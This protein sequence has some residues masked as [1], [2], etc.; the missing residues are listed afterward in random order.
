MQ[1]PAENSTQQIRAIAPYKW[2]CTSCTLQVLPF[3]INVEDISSDNDDTTP[4]I[5]HS[6]QPSLSTD[7]FK[8]M[9]DKQQHL[10]KICHLINT[11][12]MLSTFDEFECLINQYPFDIITLS[13]TWLKD[14]QHVLDYVRIPGYSIEFR[15]RK[16]RRGGGVGIYMRD[17]IKSKARSE[18]II[19]EH[20]FEHIWLEIEGKN[21]PGGLPT[22]F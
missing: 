9:I 12:S 7:K 17:N 3:F 13:E 2:I 6:E 18:I 14:N 5:N 19:L 10:L 21:K 8:S 16:D 11:Q 4:V 15:N 22:G 1:Y 20:D